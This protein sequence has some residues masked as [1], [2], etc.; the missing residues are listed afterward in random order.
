MISFSG[1]LGVFSMFPAPPRGAHEHVGESLIDS[2][3]STATQ[4]GRLVKVAEYALTVE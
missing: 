2:R 4:I 1:E 3:N